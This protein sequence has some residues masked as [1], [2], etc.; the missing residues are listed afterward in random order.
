MKDN[1]ERLVEKYADTVT[2]ICYVNLENR[3]DAEDAWQN[4]F[5]KLF[6]NEKIQ[7]KPDDEIRKWSQVAGTCRSMGI[8]VVD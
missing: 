4:V 8:T 3:A 2:R 1:F 7:Q 6:R 5:L